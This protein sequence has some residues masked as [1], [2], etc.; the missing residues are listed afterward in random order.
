MSAGELER[1]DGVQREQVYL[2]ILGQVTD[3]A[4]SFLCV[5]NH[6]E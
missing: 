1:Y 2:A 3:L 6:I 4:L 5:L